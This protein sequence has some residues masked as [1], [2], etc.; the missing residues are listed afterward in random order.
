MGDPTALVHINGIQGNIGN[1]GGYAQIGTPAFIKLWAGRVW[2]WDGNDNQHCQADL[3]WY[4]S[5]GL[6]LSFHFMSHRLAYRC[7][8]NCAFANGDEVSLTVATIFFVTFYKMDFRFCTLRS[9]GWKLGFGLGLGVQGSV[10]KV[11]NTRPW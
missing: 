2:G 11:L 6:G 3:D 5:G 4:S 9:S 8:R 7:E 10:W 1:I